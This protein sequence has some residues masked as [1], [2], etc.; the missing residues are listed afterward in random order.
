MTPDNAETF[1]VNDRTVLLLDG[2]SYP[3]F[4]SAATWTLPAFRPGMSILLAGHPKS[5]PTAL[6]VWSLLPFPH[7]DWAEVHVAIRTSPGLSRASV[8]AIDALDF[9]PAHVGLAGLTCDLFVDQVEIFSLVHRIGFRPY[10]SDGT[11]TEQRV[12]LHRPKGDPPPAKPI[13]PCRAWVPW[14]EDPGPLRPARPA[15]TASS[16]LSRKDLDLWRRHPEA[17]HHVGIP[18]TS[19]SAEFAAAIE[20][21]PGFRFQSAGPKY[22]GHWSICSRTGGSESLHLLVLDWDHCVRNARS[23]DGLRRTVRSVARPGERIL[24]PTDAAVPGSA[25]ALL[26]LRHRGSDPRGLMQRYDIDA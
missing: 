5:F 20:R 9:L 24:C 11:G 16:D 17:M 21:N 15:V 13:E 6:V 14:P 4:I 25:A 3:E 12:L 18:S 1:L 23:L 26:G 19:T 2:T 10:G 7:E 8:A 22:G